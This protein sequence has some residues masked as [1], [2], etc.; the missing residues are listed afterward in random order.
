MSVRDLTADVLVRDADDQ[1]VLLGIVLVLVLNDQALPGK[2]VGFTLAPSL[3]LYL[4]ASEVRA[5][6]LDLLENL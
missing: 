4:E 5:V 1:T 6:L 3:E 2:V